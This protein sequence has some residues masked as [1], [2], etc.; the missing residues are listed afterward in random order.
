[1][2]LETYFS[3]KLGNSPE[4][5]EDAFAFNPG[6]GKIAVADGASDSIFSGLWARSLVNSYVNSS[7]S[8]T[9]DN[10][11]ENLVSSSR[12]KWHMDIK[13]DDLKLFVRN[14]AINGSFSTL[15]LVESLEDIEFNKIR[16]LSVGDSCILFRKDDGV[17]SF[18][19]KTHEEFNITPKLVWS[20]YG[21]PFSGEYK[22]ESP[23]FLS[24][25]FDV[26]AGTTA[27]IATDAVSKWILQF[28]PKS[29]DKITD[30]ETDLR[31]M[32]E[33]QVRAGKMRND[34]LTLIQVTTDS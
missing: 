23:P 9:D 4:E 5:Y 21:S 2:K 13:W 1:M 17:E 25:D 32:F 10:F 18:P 8:I 34:D 12:K 26:E 19:L 14:K 11:M 30:H 24:E 28:Y 16:V 15:I 6:R 7:L 33:K 20:G 27:F 31:E 29:W 22:W 3:Q